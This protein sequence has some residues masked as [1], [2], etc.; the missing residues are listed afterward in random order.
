MTNKKIITSEYVSYGH[1][2][3][4]ADQIS[5][6]LLDA[7][8]IQ[9]PNTRAGIETMIKDNIIIL[10]GEVKTCGE[11]DVENTVR[12]VMDSIKYPKSHNLRGKDVKI[13]NL[14]G[15]QSE[16]ISKGVDKCDSDIIGAGDQGFMVGMASNETNEYIPLGVY[17]AR[18][19]CQSVCKIQGL[20]PDV[21]TQVCI[22]Y[23]GRKPKIKSIVVST[24]H[25][26]CIDILRVRKEVKECICSNSV[27]GDNVM[28]SETYYEYIHNNNEI[29]YYIN[30]N[31]TWNVGGPIS[32]CGLTG[33]KIVV[34]Q[35]GG[36]CNVGGGAFSGKEMSKVDRSAAYMA[37]Y[38]AKNIVD[39]GI[40][41]SAR[42]EISYIISQPE[43]CSIK[44][45][46]ENASDTILK[47]L[48]GQIEK[49]IR[50]NID[51]TPN[52]IINRFFPNGIK[53]IFFNTARNGHFGFNNL[54]EWYPW[55]KTDIS[56]K[57]KE[58]IE[59]TEINLM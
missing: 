4:V 18:Q 8:I 44:V 59:E 3:K 23:S 11:I 28:D 10:G 47:D 31:G 26:S 20:G 38:L 2:D 22:D 35:Y 24:M 48:S 42:V 5:D 53:P 9:D 39:A 13:I 29:E 49:Y 37:R 6:A 46:L 36:Y 33:R 14:I 21:K 55:E 34:D 40:A 19:I 30:V 43:P 54:D 12:D 1:P 27:Y 50:E 16:E 57:L 58:Y 7:Y 32:D 15:K 51:L 17:I 45:E 56:S 52:G 25:L 41:E